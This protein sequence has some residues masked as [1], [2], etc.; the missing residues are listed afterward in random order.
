MPA[1]GHGK[2]ERDRVTPVSRDR[3]LTMPAGGVYW[4]KR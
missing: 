3:I 2:K 1:I 4:A